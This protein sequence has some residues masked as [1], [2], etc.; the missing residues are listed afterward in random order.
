[1]LLTFH[2]GI[3]MAKRPKQELWLLALAVVLLFSSPA[4]AELYIA[5]QFGVSVPNSLSNVEGVDS[6]SGLNI[7]NLKLQDSFTYGAKLGYYFNSIKWLGIETEVYNTTPNS[8]QQ[9]VTINGTPVNLVGQ[10]IRVL[11]WAPIMVM[12]RYPGERFQPYAGVGPGVFFA[13]VHD[14]QSNESS[15]SNQVGLNT[16]LGLRFLVTKHFSLFGEWKYNRV[17]FN[18]SDSRPTAATG[19]LKGDF[20]ANIFVF[21]LGWHF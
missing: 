8:K 12:I 1:M 6:S 16:Q 18:F 9:N 17:T 10:D 19:G 13:R 5:G 2:G 3:S 4:G 20:S 11:T 21:G 14:G 15:D 7:S